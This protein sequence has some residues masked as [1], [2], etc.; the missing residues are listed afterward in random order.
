[1]E[2]IGYL[3]R[4]YS[5]KRKKEVRF[6]SQKCRHLNK[7]SLLNNLKGIK[8]IG[9]WLQLLEISRRAPFDLAS[10]LNC[11]R[12]VVTDFSLLK[13]PTDPNSINNMY[14]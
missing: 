7:D 14:I 4:F 6:L 11:I 13:Q 1:M 10:P 8:P 2:L 9:L 3:L 12:L 5:L